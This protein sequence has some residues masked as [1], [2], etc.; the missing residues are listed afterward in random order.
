MSTQTVRLYL[1]LLKNCL[2]GELYLDDEARLYYLRECLEGKD[3]FNLDTYIHIETQRPEMSERFRELAYDGRF[4]EDKL[5]KIGFQHTLIGRLR[6]ENL[7]WCLDEIV[8][9][10]VPGDLIEC[11]VWRG[12]ASV[13]MRGYLADAGITGRSV[14]VADSF[15]GPP[16]PSL[17]QDQGVDLS[18]ARYPVLAV[19]ADRVRDLFARYRLLD[20]Q[21]HFLEGWFKDTLPK[22]PIHELA[23]LRVDA[24]L[25][26]STRD[27]LNA[28]YDRVSYGG[29]VI[30]DDYG[31]IPACREAVDEFRKQR[32]IQDPISEIDWTGVYWRKHAAASR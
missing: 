22:A 24:D 20:R 18:A 17:P 30:I 14:W 9:E 6:L 28:L 27:A 5:E 29:F 12:G 23:L 11:G 3:Q 7:E 4:P 10:A 16:P 13:F 19:S 25:Y 32:G 8:R 2:T 21:V 26:E 15:N 1:D 31:C